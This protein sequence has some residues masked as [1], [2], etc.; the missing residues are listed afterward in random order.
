MGL[1]FV[2]LLFLVGISAQVPTRALPP[3]FGCAVMRTQLEWM[4][5]TG[6]SQVTNEAVLLMR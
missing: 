1:A 4:Q 5:L 3:G 6:D 2:A